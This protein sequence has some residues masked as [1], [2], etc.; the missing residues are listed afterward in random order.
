MA[1]ASRQATETRYAGQR[2]AAFKRAEDILGQEQAQA[3]ITLRAIT[4]E[5][6]ATFGTQWQD[7]AQRLYPW[8]WHQM[9][10][11]YRRNEP[12]RFE[13]AVWSAETL[14]GLALGRLRA[15]YCSLDYI[16][17]SPAPAHPLRG[18]VI[19]AVLTALTAYAVALGRAEIRLID[20]FPALVPRYENLGFMLATPKREAR[21]WWKEIP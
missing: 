9:A 2:A 13:A 1:I 18:M 5:T 3:P 4:P 6:L 11:D 20:P 8:P 21:Y 16:E 10:G 17:G 15:R 19:P 14:C 12:T 7:H